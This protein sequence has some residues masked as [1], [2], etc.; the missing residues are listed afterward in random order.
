MLK[1]H[2][3]SAPTCLVTSL[4]R[5]SLV[6]VKLIPA[7]LHVTVGDLEPLEADPHQRWRHTHGMD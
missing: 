2:L 7:G 4:M 3:R 1:R 5:V 6:A